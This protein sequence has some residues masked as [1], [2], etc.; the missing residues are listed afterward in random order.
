MKEREKKISTIQKVSS[1]DL[2]LFLTLALLVVLL[3]IWGTFKP[4]H[5]NWGTHVFSFYPRGISL[6]FLL[7]MILILH[8]TAARRS[9]QFLTRVVDAASR[10]PRVLSVTISAACVILAAFLFQVKMHLLG[11]GAVLLR[12]N[13]LA[14]WGNDLIRSFSNQPLMLLIYR[15]VLTFHLWNTTPSPHEI[16]FSID[17]GASV[18]FV[19]LLYWF[20]RWYDQPAVDSLL[21]ALIVFLSASTQFFFGYVENYVLQFVF[22]AFF[23]FA[24]WR[25]LRGSTSIIFPVISFVIIIGLHLG[26]LILAPA[27]AFLLYWKFRASKRT[28]FFV[29]LAALICGFGFMLLVGFNLQGFLRHITSGSVDFLQLFTANGGNFPYPMFSLRH[30]WDWLNGQFLVAPVGLVIGVALLITKRRSIHWQDPVFIFLSLAT[31]CGLIFTW[32]VNFALGMARDWD[33]F[34]TF[35]TPLLV[36]D[37][38]LLT[39]IE[40]P[41]LRRYYLITVVV[42]TAAHWVAWIGINAD[43]QRHLA[44]MKLLN[45]T[46]FLSPVSRMVFDEALANYFFDSQQ[47]EDARRYYEDFMTVDNHNPRIVGNI[48]DTYR[49]LGLKDKYFAMLQRAVALDSH[50]P[51]VYSNLGVE[52]ANRGDTAKAI[53]F[54]ERAVQMDSTHRLAHANLGILYA[55]QRN[56]LLADQH[57]RTAIDLGMR[58]A[59]LFRYAADVCV[60]LG[61]YE[62]ALEYY[63]SYLESVPNDQRVLAARNQIRAIL[64]KNHKP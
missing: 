28:L 21:A 34:S 27:V 17:L 44:R 9:V 49:K 42:I 55:T 45:D 60:Y 47:Y 52:Y 50:D 8:P 38:Y 61:Q 1:K 29:G 39:T 37:V 57:F 7:V 43:A 3:H 25:S 10:V 22:G 24:G 5:L 32:I 59:S 19:L 20:F 16:Y 2:L 33:L 31:V 14:E 30:V 35:I 12:S 13:A 26:F 18:L 15:W 36:L 62:R 64:L 11:D 4:S 23:L 56:F 6:M 40:S 58:D 46:H 54:N 63:N 53:A 51:G 48:A 41:A